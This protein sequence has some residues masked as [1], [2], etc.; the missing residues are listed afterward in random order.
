MPAATAP[1]T[2]PMP[3]M[4]HMPGAMTMPGMAPGASPVLVYD[5]GAA[6]TATVA[7]GPNMARDTDGAPA[8]L[9][10]AAP[11]RGFASDNSSARSTKLA[12]PAHTVAQGTLIPAVLETAIDSDVPGFVR[13]VVSQDVRS[14]DGSRS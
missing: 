9:A 3:G 12:D 8:M 5:G 14:F 7:A 10:G 4:A 2:N 1:Q 6:P 13:A 11:S